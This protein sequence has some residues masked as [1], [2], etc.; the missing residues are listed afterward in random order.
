MCC[1][2]LESQH[3]DLSGSVSLNLAIWSHGWAAS[4]LLVWYGRGV[5]CSVYII[6]DVL[7]IDILC[8][9]VFIYDIYIYAYI[10]SYSMYQIVYI[11]LLFWMFSL[12]YIH[13]THESSC[14]YTWTKD[15]YLQSIEGFSKRIRRMIPLRTQH[16]IFFMNV[17]KTFRMFSEKRQKNY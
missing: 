3:P 16:T 9:V 17:W 15:L 5:P 6:G 8:I 10:H 14:Q 1:R 7:I 2:L 4:Q 13:C 12:I 11:Y